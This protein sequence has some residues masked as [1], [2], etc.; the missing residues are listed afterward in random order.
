[1]AE[2]GENGG[3]AERYW[4]LHRERG[5]GGAPL[6]GYGDHFAGG[7]VGGG[8]AHRCAQREGDAVGYIQVDFTGVNFQA[9]RERDFISFQKS[10]KERA[11]DEKN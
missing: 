1:M 3:Y 6:R 4:H 7:R 9:I 8:Q 10:K 11:G 5:E 2:E